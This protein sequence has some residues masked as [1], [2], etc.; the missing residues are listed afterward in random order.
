M[1]FRSVSQSRYYEAKLS[2]EKGR[3]AKR[4]PL[5]VFK[6]GISQGIFESATYLERH[7]EELFGVKF[8][9]ACITQSCLNKPKYM[10][11][12]GYEFNYITQEEYDNRKAE[13]NLKQAM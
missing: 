1:L 5:E 8:V 4:I 2:L 12:K 10:K 11:Y 6:N 9:R 3:I 7:S 13:E